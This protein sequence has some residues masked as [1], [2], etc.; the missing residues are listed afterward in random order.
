MASRT[1]SDPL[2]THCRRELFHEAW[3]LMLDE[4]FIKAYKEGIIVD[5]SDGIRRRLFPRILTYSADYPE[6]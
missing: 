5:C 3:K 2:I 1:V 4:D 6:K